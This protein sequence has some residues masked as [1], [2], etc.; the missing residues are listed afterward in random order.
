MTDQLRF[1]RKSIARE[2]EVD[3]EA[4]YHADLPRLYNFFRYRVGYN[5]V[6][7]SIP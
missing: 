3:W 4:A 6:A 2:R 1:F 5:Q 7:E